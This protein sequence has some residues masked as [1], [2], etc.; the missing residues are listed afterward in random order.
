MREFFHKA[1]ADIFLLI[2]L[3]I[4][5]MS[6]GALAEPVRVTVFGDSLV[7]GYGL[8]RQ[9]GL[10]PQLE[11]WLQDREVDAALFNA[12]V[13]GDTTAGGL[14]R[15]EWTLADRPDAVVIL[16]GGNDLLRGLDPESSRRNLGAIVD[17][18][19]ASGMEVLLVGHEA[20][21]NFGLDYKRDFEAIFV[22]LADG[23]DIL[24]F[25][26]YFSPLDDL[27]ERDEVRRRYMQDDGLH[28]NADGV[29]EIVGKL[30]P[31][32]AELV[33]RARQN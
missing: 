8:P 27:G 19:I 21:S 16:F 13:S 1:T 9:D 17:G 18:A 24:L 26:R 11:S 5:M 7:Q 12:G 2:T 23:R 33:E 3:L 29:A 15:L 32:V 14:A 22:G 20:P 28:P 25:E 31:I 4:T 10:V 30:G 6:A